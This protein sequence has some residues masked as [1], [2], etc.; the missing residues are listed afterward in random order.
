IPN[1]SANFLLLETKAQRE[2]AVRREIKHRIKVRRIGEIARIG[3][4]VCRLQREEIFALARR[5][6]PIAQERIAAVNDVRITEANKASSARRKGERASP[7]ILPAVIGQ[8]TPVF[9]IPQFKPA[10]LVA[11]SNPITVHAA[12][13]SAVCKEG[14][15]LT[16]ARTRF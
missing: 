3:G 12:G 11:H 2:S 14:G 1:D 8:T 7:N 9:H 16:H 13:E 10:Q 6:L 5:G 15:Q 4:N